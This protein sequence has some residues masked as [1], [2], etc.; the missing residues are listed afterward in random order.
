[1]TTDKELTLLKF[2][3][4]LY[5]RMQV[6]GEYKVCRLIQCSK[7]QKPSKSTIKLG[8]NKMIQMIGIFRAGCRRIDS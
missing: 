1:M 8:W 7:E 4:D 2:I 5:L 3:G 6:A